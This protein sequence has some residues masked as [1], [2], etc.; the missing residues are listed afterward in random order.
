MSIL[1]KKKI[2]G[3]A[4][5]IALMGGGY[6]F[7]T[8]NT[9]AS[10][11]GKFAKMNMMESV[12]HPQFVAVS[13]G[14]IDIQDGIS[15]INANMSGVIKQVFVSEGDT[16]KK[17]QILAL[18]ENQEEIIAVKQ[19]QANL[20]SQMARAELQLIQNNAAKRELERLTPL[21]KIGAVTRKEFDQT[22]DRVLQGA[23][24]VKINAASLMQSQTRLTQA[25]FKLEQRSIRAPL[26][27][28]I[29]SVKARPGVGAS[30][31]N[32][33]ALFTIIPNSE[34]IVRAVI[35]DSVMSDIFEGQDALVYS[36]IDK[37]KQY[38]AKV[39]RISLYIPV[40][41]NDIARFFRRGRAQTIDV[42]L[43]MGDS[44]LLIGQKVQVRFLREGVD[45]EAALKEAQKQ[46]KKRG[47]KKNPSM[48]NSR[49]T[50]II[51]H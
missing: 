21:H 13:S 17:D 4:V 31:Q 27:G 47:R 5:L 23:V 26:D 15:N 42:I 6:W 12:K 7:Y 8:D 51:R 1:T 41:S 46:G 10:K 19:A 2:I 48:G 16:V 38:P 50:F 9:A 11:G 22:N 45:A 44:P 25:Q 37:S 43:D 30:T 32:V 33:T 20:S 39:N 3:A 29:V 14:L 24:N 40:S 34:R 36:N 28:Q 18:Q 49:R 35:D